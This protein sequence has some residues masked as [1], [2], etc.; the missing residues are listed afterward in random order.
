VHCFWQCNNPDGPASLNRPLTRYYLRRTP[1][2]SARF[3]RSSQNKCAQVHRPF[4]RVS[5]WTG[6]R[7]GGLVCRSVTI[8]PDGPLVLATGRPAGGAGR[9]WAP[10]AAAALRGTAWGVNRRRAALRCHGP[11]SP[12][13]IDVLVLLCEIDTTVAAWEHGKRRSTGCTSWPPATGVLW[14]AL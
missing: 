10:V 11:R 13:R 8:N 6:V 2:H 3:R 4:A 12:C 5:N 9:R 14:T 1:S 7:F